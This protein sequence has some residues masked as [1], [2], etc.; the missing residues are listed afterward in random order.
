VLL[1][2]EERIR[3]LKRRKKGRK[4]CKECAKLSGIWS[5]DR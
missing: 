3:E 5:D 1:Q 2:D 4:E